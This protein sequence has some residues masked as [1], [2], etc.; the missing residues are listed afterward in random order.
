MDSV[1]LLYMSSESSQTIHSTHAAI[2]PQLRPTN[3]LPKDST[4]TKQ[5]PTP[6]NHPTKSRGPIA[7]L[8]MLQEVACII[9]PSKTHPSFGQ[10][11]IAKMKHFPAAPLCMVLAQLRHAAGRHRDEARPRVAPED[12]RIRG[13]HQ[14]I[15]G[16][17]EGR[18]GS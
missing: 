17:T 16:H 15:K 13:S 14:S 10:I 4:K 1:Y 5:T 2:Q 6:S 8:Q 3:P 9:A 18:Q 11:F 12:R 7:Q